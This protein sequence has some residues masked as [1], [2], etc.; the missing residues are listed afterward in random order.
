MKNVKKIWFVVLLLSGL[1][2]SGSNCMLFANDQKPINFEVF[3]NPVVEDNF[4][5]TSEI[6]ITEVNILNI[7]GQQ[8]LTDKFS[9][10]T[11]I[12][13]HFKTRD[14]GLYIIQVKTID[15]RVTTKRVLFK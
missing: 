13:I 4:K 3:P 7:L 1:I 10:E 14:K 12:Y 2:A 6:E 5:L 9:G 8:V 15:G 11:N